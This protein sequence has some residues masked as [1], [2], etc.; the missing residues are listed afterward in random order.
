MHSKPFSWRTTAFPLS[1]RQTPS[2]IL[3]VYPII[4]SLKSWC[5]RINSEIARL[6]PDS[7]MRISRPIKGRLALLSFSQE[8]CAK[9]KHGAR[10]MLILSVSLTKPDAFIEITTAVL[11]LWIPPGMSAKMRP[12][13][14]QTFGN[15]MASRE[16]G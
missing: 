2:W 10:C 4:I 6:F 12:R 9:S 15:I 5:V 1:E 14:R 8:N 3:H 16:M 13:R 11:T 7:L